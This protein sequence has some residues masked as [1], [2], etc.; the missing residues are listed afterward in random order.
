MGIMHNCCGLVGT[1]LLIINGIVFTKLGRHVSSAIPLTRITIFQVL[2]SEFFYNPQ[3][4]LAEQENR[5]VTQ[6]CF[7]QWTKHC[8]KTE[9]WFSRNLTV[10]RLTSVLLLTTSALPASIL[11]AATHL[12]SYMVNMT[13]K[14]K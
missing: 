2:G 4:E 7:G 11:V 3:P 13:H 6:Q 14:M 10:L 12:I 5:C 9:M 1:Y 8:E